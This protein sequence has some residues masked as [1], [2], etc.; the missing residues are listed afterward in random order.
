MRLVKGGKDH[1]RRRFMRAESNTFV[2]NG[3]R[4]RG[5]AEKRDLLSC[6]GGRRERETPT[7]GGARRTD[8]VVCPV[9]ERLRDVKWS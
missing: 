8:R 6:A 4:Q 7:F 5:P 2:P 9:T 1:R 3:R